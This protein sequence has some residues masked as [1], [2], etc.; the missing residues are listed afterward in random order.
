M[1]KTTS[2][3]TVP[4]RYGFWR[5]W[6]RH[7]KFSVFLFFCV[8]FFSVFFKQVVLIIFYLE[9]LISFYT[10]LNLLPHNFLSHTSSFLYFSLLLV[11]ME[12]L[13]YYNPIPVYFI[14]FW[15]G[16]SLY[17]FIFYILLVAHALL[18]SVC[19]VL[20]LESFRPSFPV[21]TTAS[22]R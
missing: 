1:V 19:T 18:I 20:V 3:D 15:K 9:S 17:C 11:L 6:T 2:L 14:C 4:K 21:I 8:K 12:V 13:S 22:A 10:W 7:S 5:N 16:I